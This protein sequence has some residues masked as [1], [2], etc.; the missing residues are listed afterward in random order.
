MEQHSHEIFFCFAKFNTHSFNTLIA[1]H[2]GVEQ[3][4]EIPKLG[5]HGFGGEGAPAGNL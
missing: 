3:L 5:K 2:D 4:F 1:F